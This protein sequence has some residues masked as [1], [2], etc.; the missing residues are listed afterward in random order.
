MEKAA[1]LYGKATSESGNR[2]TFL[3]LFDKDK[4]MLIKLGVP[5]ISEEARQL[6]DRADV[7]IAKGQ[8]NF[9]TLNGCGLNIYYLFLCKCDW[10]VRLFNAKPLEGMFVNERRVTPLR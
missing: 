6:L 9:E 4:E 10:F 7:I 1:E 3:E 2:E 8:G 5:D